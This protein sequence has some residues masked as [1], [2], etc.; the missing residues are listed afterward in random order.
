MQS[1]LGSQFWVCDSWGD[2]VMG[3]HASAGLRWAVPRLQALLA[4]S[5]QASFVC[6]V[7]GRAR[8]PPLILGVE[9]TWIRLRVLGIQQI[10]AAAVLRVMVPVPLQGRGWLLLQGRVRSWPSG[11]SCPVHTSTLDI[12]VRN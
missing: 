8:L 10:V 1:T 7:W 12:L 2:R 9:R 5:S 6:V 4:V 3:V 11:R